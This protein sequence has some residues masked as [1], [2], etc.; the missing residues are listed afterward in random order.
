MGYSLT[1]FFFFLL[2][3]NKFEIVSQAQTVMCLLHAKVCK[4]LDGAVY[5]VSLSEAGSHLPSPQS[6]CHKKL[7][8]SASLLRL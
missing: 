5:L 1:F 6:N 2:I 8:K 4:L 3:L 7:H